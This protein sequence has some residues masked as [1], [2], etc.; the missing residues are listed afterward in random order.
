MDEASAVVA[1]Y[2]MERLTRDG[3]SRDLKS[4]AAMPVT[5]FGIFGLQ[6][7]YDD[8]LNLSRSWGSTRSTWPEYVQE[9]MIG[10][11]TERAGVRVP[12]VMTGNHLSCRWCAGQAAPG[13][14]GGT[15]SRALGLKP[16]GCPARYVM[17][18][19]GDIPVA[20]AYLGSTPVVTTHHGPVGSVGPARR[21]SR[22]PQGSRC[23]SLRT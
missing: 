15:T 14:S 19:R 21:R 17:A 7:P 9:D 23:T 6:F 5:L 18:Y 4:E 16:V 1:H 10:I 3:S 2:Q 22:S 11:N 13:A 8:A 12:E 20:R